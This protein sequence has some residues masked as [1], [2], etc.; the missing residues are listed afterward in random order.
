MG[1]F[2]I[3]IDAVGGHG[4]D[5]E[6]KDGE[7]VDFTHSGS[8]YHSSK[9]PE[10]IAQVLVAA[11]QGTGCSI[12]SAKVIHWPADNYGGPEK[13][14]RDPQKQIVD[15]LITGKRSGNF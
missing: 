5:R 11:L 10:S 14:G 4:Q 8:G 13:N 12:E 6:K 15:C 7:V 9:N 3:I 2:R 1:D